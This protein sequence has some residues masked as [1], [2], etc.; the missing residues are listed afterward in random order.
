MIE[1]T[2]RG[3]LVSEVGT[4]FF[5]HPAIQKQDSSKSKITVAFMIVRLRRSLGPL[6][7]TEG[8]YL[9]LPASEVFLR[10]KAAALRTPSFSSVRI[11]SRE[12]IARS[13]PISPKASAAER[14]TSL[15]LS[16]R[17]AAISAS[18]YTKARAETANAI[19]IQR[20]LI[21][22]IPLSIG[23]E[24]PLDGIDAKENNL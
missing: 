9:T 17:I 1:G 7:S 13:S 4:P 18:T 23:L 20:R 14:R 21:L 11:A 12:G 6:V 19:M 15:L 2:G 8:I 22:D 5:L 3:G 10:A 24:H 16:S